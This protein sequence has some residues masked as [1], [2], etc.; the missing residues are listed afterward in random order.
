MFDSVVF[1]GGGHRCWWQL[2][3]WEVVSEQIALAPR[4]IAGVSAGA[5]TACMLFANN[6]SAALAYYRRELGQ[7]AKNF[8]PGHLL[9][10]GHKVLP[11]EQ[12][13]RGALA[14]L[15]G[16]QAFERLMK[17]A[18]EIRIMYAR[19]PQWLPPMM[20]VGAGLTAYNIE[21]YWLSPLHPRF[22]VALGFKPEVALVNQC[23]DQQ[24]LIDLIIASSST[25]PF[26][27]VQRMGGRPVLDGGLIDNVPVAA[28]AP[29]ASEEPTRASSSS[30]A[31]PRTLVLVTRRYKK[32]PLVFEEADR[33]Y[34][35]P[36]RKVAASSWD[37]TNPDAYAA[38]LE[39]GREDARFFLEYIKNTNERDR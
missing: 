13:Y 16:G 3:W 30:S 7:D 22:G 36:S 5:A 8:Y 35:Q 26:T 38:T 23:T 18:P 20:A 14:E 12:I 1:A 6:S 33:L 17:T 32:Y 27:T 21:K 24:A 2:G 19:P 39:Q 29:L 11:H 15:L 9:K 31:L 28:L 4:Q 34:V 10:P 25:P 37:Y